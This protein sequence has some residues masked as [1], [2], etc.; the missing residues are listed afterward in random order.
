MRIKFRIKIVVLF[1]II[2]VFSVTD[3]LAQYSYINKRWN[4][5]LGYARYYAGNHVGRHFYIFDDGNT[6]NYRI[7]ANYGTLNFIESGAY[8]GYS[9]FTYLREIVPDSFNTGGYSV[10]DNNTFFYGIGINLHIL[11]FLIKADDFRFDLYLT[12]KL[13]G[14][15]FTKPT[16]YSIYGHPIELL[17]GGG[18][19]FYPGKHIGL[20]ME[21]CYGKYPY[22]DKTNLRYGL[23]FKF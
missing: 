2:G 23:T 17:F 12:A 16:D 20:F 21:Y 15:Y 14:F 6:G 18:L 5:K 7:E 8:F 19:S 9:K 10:E 13:G 11:P 22:G 4:I 1:V 3:L